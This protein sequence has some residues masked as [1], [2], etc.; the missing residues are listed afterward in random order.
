MFLQ[1]LIGFPD[2]A[3]LCYFFYGITENKSQNSH[4]GMTLFCD[5]LLTYRNAH[6]RSSDFAVSIS[7]NQDINIL[8]QRDKC[9]PWRN[10]HGRIRDLEYLLQYG[11]E[12]KENQIKKP[13]IL[14]SEFTKKF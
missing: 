1:S 3:F 4:G 6:P 10:F 13:N 7:T 5:M 8:F 11:L 14:L 12:I 9:F 2:T